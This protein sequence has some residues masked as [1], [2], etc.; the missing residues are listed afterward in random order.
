MHTVGSWSLI[1]NKRQASGN[2]KIGFSGPG[3]VEKSN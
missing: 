3:G 1:Y 2:R